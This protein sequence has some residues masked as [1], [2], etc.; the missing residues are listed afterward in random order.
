MGMDQRARPTITK[1]QGES[2]FQTGFH[3]QVLTLAPM[4]R[5]LPSLDPT[6]TCDDRGGSDFAGSCIWRS[7]HA[8]IEH[9]HTSHGKHCPGSLPPSTETYLGAYA[10]RNTFQVDQGSTL[11]KW[12]AVD[13]SFRTHS[14][15]SKVALHT[16]IPLCEKGL[17]IPTTRDGRSSRSGYYKG[18]RS[19]PFDVSGSMAYQHNYYIDEFCPPGVFVGGS[20]G[21]TVEWLAVRLQSTRS[22]Y[23]PTCFEDRSQPDAC[24]RQRCLPYR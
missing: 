24:P 15:P 21:A 5:R 7:K 22:T 13:G 10:T 8:R 6:C 4:A 20:M 11:R 14:I 2:I 3:D 1:P 17:E 19:G 16:G 9:F 12:S 18:D 23:P